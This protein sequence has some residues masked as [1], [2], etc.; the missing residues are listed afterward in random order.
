MRLQGPHLYQVLQT[1]L[2]DHLLQCLEIDSSTTA[3]SL[4]LTV[5]IMFMPHLCN[6]LAVY[7]PRLFIVY[8][9]VL[10]WDKF[11][12][13]RQDA[14]QNFRTDTPL[15]VEKYEDSIT[16][17]GWQKLNSS[18]ETATST[19]PEV[20]D[21]FSF[22]YGLYPINFLSFIREP[23]K[24]LERANYMDLDRLDIDEEAIRQRTELYRQHHIL[25]P[26]FLTLT[27]D[28]ELSDQTRW[29][30][31]EPADVTAQCIGLV[32]NNI[33]TEYIWSKQQNATRCTIPE[34]LIPTEDIPN[35]SLLSRRDD[36][37]SGD[38]VEGVWPE[39]TTLRTAGEHDKQT[40][41]SDHPSRNA[42]AQD[43]PTIPASGFEPPDEA[44]LQNMLSLQEQLQASIRDLKHAE[45]PS[46]S[47]DSHHPSGP[48]P[49]YPGS[50]TA[51]PHLDA[52]VQ[53][54]NHNNT[55]RSPA[56]RP[57]PSDTQGTIAYLQREVMLLKNDL[58]FERY[59]KQQHLSHIGHLQRKHIKE[60]TAE[61]ET[62]NLINTNKTLKAKLE[63]AKKAYAA[64]R[65]EALKSKNQAKKW[66]AELSTKFR[67][68]R[69]E[70]K[71]WR[72]ET[73]SQALEASRAE[74]EHLQ[75]LLED[76][77]AEGLRARQKL[78]NMNVNIDEVNK[79]R[80]F[81]D[82]LSNKL[83]DYDS[84]AQEFEMQRHNEENALQ[85][86]ESMK[87]RLT[88]RDQEL[89]EMKR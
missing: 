1:P 83:T 74:A 67:A 46:S 53:S 32:N 59:L 78:Q 54:L 49:G 17:S 15:S 3:I 89:Q 50:A 48:P 26:N 47:H 88:S 34:A 36:Y 57:S 71:A 56:L 64:S 7:L 31:V 45:N 61:A 14:T 22:L 28:T 39:R 40:G 35:E 5:L 86:V 13:A 72:Q 60:S 33:P 18:F 16:V 55:P 85:Q 80:T 51:S 70:Q 63:E 82:H 30:R 21:Y 19:T 27:T 62:Q 10:C 8:T 87:I 29:M 24:F 66:E 41:G 44:H 11:G 69:E 65:Q 4:A 2:L 9:R 58:N 52:Y 6:S 20:G 68:L 77:E 73:T 76:S 42:E 43:S 37:S 23:Y 25:H 84:R 38:D 79:L 81:V 12:I 75:K